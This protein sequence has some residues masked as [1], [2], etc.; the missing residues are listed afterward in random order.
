MSLRLRIQLL[1]TT[2]MVCM[3]V[4]LCWR[5][6]D[7]TRRSV[8][9]EMEAANR[10]A[11]QVLRVVEQRPFNEVQAMLQSLGRVRANF[12]T[13]SDSQHRIVYASP[14]SPYKPGRYAP[15]W[16]ASVVTP[17]TELREIALP[18]GLLQ[19]RADPS[20]AVLD[21][22]DDFLA[23]LVYAGLFLLLVSAITA[24]V[25]HQALRPLSRIE[26]ALRSL[27]RGRF[28]TR[29]PT[30]PGR[31]AAL[32]SQ[33]FNDMAQAIEEN[34]HAKDE[35]RQAQAKL[36]QNRELT[37]VILQ[38]IEA[39]RGRIARE[40]HDEL[41]QQLTAVRTLSQVLL[42]DPSVS[43]A[44]PDVARLLQQATGDMYD[45]LH[46][47][48]PR[49]RPL[50]LDRLGL[51]EALSDLL[52]DW[53]QLAPTVRFELS[54]DTLPA[55]L[56]DTLATAIYRIVQE[57]LT[58]VVKHAQASHVVVS[59]R[60]QG[61]QLCLS[62]SDNGVGL[63]SQ[64]QANGHHGLIG[65]R[66]RAQALGGQCLLGSGLISG[67]EGQGGMSVQVTLPWSAPD[68]PPLPESRPT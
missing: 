11:I 17:T 46:R 57:S 2:L 45:S 36:A 37:Q 6:I 61:G 35:A 8:R 63:P 41:G 16:F 4:T 65:I 28:D 3:V 51:A 20:R 64:W 32:M 25:L 5:E 10:V 50:A 38:R 48:L 31:E 33:A 58:N 13:L 21:G 34:L 39:E 53:R 55:D 40:L 56:G 67:H 29:L 15:E 30:L 24:V 22:W 66:E 23:M 18:E 27:Q 62:V 19:V 42:Q 52:I 43:Q 59:L 68:T 60:R 26:D 47:M 44:K 12:L 7:G 1:V 9:E 49:L 54:L 14:E